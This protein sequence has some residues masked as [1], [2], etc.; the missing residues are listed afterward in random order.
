[1]A[2]IDSR[3][4]LA[5]LREDTLACPSP[6]SSGARSW[7]P[8]FVVA[9][10]RP[11]VGKT[12]VARLVADFLRLDGGLVYAFDLDPGESGLA[13]VLP[14]VTRKADI[15]ST[16][17]Q[18]ALFDRLITDDGVPKIVDL[19]P[20]LFE[21]FFALSEEIGFIEE[22]ARRS[23]EPVILF[24][25][26]PHPASA[27]AYRMLQERFADAIVVPVFNQ[28][29]LK[30]RKVRDKF[31]FLRASS[32]PLEIPI[33]PPALKAHTDVTSLSFADL[34]NQLPV[35]VPIGHAFELRSWTKRVFLEFREL[36]LRL[37]LERLRAS[38]RASS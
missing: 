23:L 21:R 34:H 4:I 24:A 33:L 3:K 6:R 19:S 25:A 29:I 7:T 10:P 13:D 38:L 27:Q 11:M 36:E 20:G 9:S 15:A 1:V 8:L 30:G 22:A 17:G 37:L 26:D 16:Q 32:V 2:M 5:N 31:P 18:M 14:L 35:E 12:F 28:A